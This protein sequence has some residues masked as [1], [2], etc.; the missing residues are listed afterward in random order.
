MRRGICIKREVKYSPNKFGIRPRII[1]VHSSKFYIHTYLQPPTQ[2]RRSQGLVT[3]FCPTFAAISPAPLLSIHAVE[4]RFTDT[5]LI[6]TPR[7]YGQFSWSLRK[8]SPHLFSKFKPL[9]TDG[10][11]MSTTET[12][13]LVQSTDSP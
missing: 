11:S 3:R 8:V 7:Y 6:R 4:A 5:R 13:F 1:I 10:P 12:C 9:N 2:T